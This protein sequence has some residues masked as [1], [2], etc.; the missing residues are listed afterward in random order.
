M[1]ALLLRVLLLCSLATPLF[2]QNCDLAADSTAGVLNCTLKEYCNDDSLLTVKQRR[3]NA[4]V[5]RN[6]TG[7]LNTS[8]TIAVQEVQRPCEDPYCLANERVFVY[9]NSLIS[10]YTTTTDLFSG[11][12]QGI[13]EANYNFTCDA[14]RFCQPFCQ[15]FKVNGMSCNSCGTCL[16]N[17]LG[18]QTIFDCTNLVLGFERD[19]EFMATVNSDDIE[20]ELFYYANQVTLQ[21]APTAAPT[22]APTRAPTASPTMRNTTLNTA[23]SAARSVGARAM[24]GASLLALWYMLH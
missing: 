16:E 8:F 14:S 6:C 1:R 10:S 15:S 7:N 18:R 21:Y 19:C 2:A 22:K 17:P 3:E 9:N 5:L 12:Y 20:S 24:G 13:L 4:T 11:R 23:T